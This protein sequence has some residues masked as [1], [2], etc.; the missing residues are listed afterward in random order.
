VGLVDVV[1]EDE[2][3]MGL[4]HRQVAMTHYVEQY[5]CADGDGDA[6]CRWRCR[7]RMQMQMEMQNAD[8]EMMGEEVGSMGEG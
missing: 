1:S 2:C 3:S 4:L 5:T 8:A 7:C 6:E